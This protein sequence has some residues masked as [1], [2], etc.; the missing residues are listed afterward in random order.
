MVPGAESGTN[1]AGRPE[2]VL[3]AVGALKSQYCE[4]LDSQQWDRWTDLFT[5]DAVMQVG[6][7]ADS[8]VHGRRAIR[9]LLATQLRGAKT[10]HQARNPELHDDGPGQ[11]RVLWE[12][13]DRVSTPLYLLEGAGFYEDRY[14]QTDDGWK[15][16]G[17]RLHRSKVDLQ[18]K[19]FVMRA[20]LAM[21][22]N[23]W[24][25]RLSK[26]ANRTLGEALFVGLAPGERPITHP[27]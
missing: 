24:F 8:A 17:V 10:L 15:I 16:A 22:R 2:G 19:S 13:T 25:G 4:R 9:R 11:V 26:S 12:T 5:E 7:S 23:G 27:P 3:E 21:H 14:V 6:P 20:I 1:D 18:A